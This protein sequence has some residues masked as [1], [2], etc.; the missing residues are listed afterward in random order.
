MKSKIFLLI[1]LLVI[2]VAFLGLLSSLSDHIPR[3]PWENITPGPVTD[4]IPPADGD[5]G[6]FCTMDAMMCPDGSYV[7]RVPP[8]CQFSACPRR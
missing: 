5:T 8:S 6:V 7:G 4:N 2:L 1:V 3:P